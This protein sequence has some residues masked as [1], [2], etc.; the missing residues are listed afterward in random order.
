[1][2]GWIWL[3]S[4]SGITVA[5]KPKILPLRAVCVVCVSRWSLSQ[6]KVVRMRNYYANHKQLYNKNL[7]KMSNFTGTHK[8]KLYNCVKTSFL[9]SN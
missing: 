3:V 6:G 7:L 1:M 5:P 4:A 9:L 2:V 8:K